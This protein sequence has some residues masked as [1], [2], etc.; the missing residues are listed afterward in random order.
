MEYFFYYL[1]IHFLIFVQEFCILELNNKLTTFWLPP[2]D[3][4]IWPI[5]ILVTNTNDGREQV[6]NKKRT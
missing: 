5:L 4:L 6:A 3:A 2:E 1:S